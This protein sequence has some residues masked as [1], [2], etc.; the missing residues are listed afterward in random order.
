MESMAYK[1]VKRRGH[2][3]C[4]PGGRMP[5]HRWVLYER[6][7]PGWHPCHHCGVLVEWRVGVYTKAGALIAEHLD[8]DHTNNASENIVP[9]CQQ[10]NLLKSTRAIK[11]TEQFVVTSEGNRAR[12]VEHI[13]E[14]C[15]KRFLVRGALLRCQS[16]KSGTGRFC[17]RQCWYDRNK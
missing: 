1:Y 14:R 13:C 6:I 16:P 4:P 9:S 17:S 8:G 12:A 7:G 2:P 11:S 3:M 10:C 5:Y 15:G